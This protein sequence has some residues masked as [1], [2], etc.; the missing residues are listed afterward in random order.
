ME[1]SPGDRFR[2]TQLV[3]GNSSQALGSPIR[4]TAIPSAP[5]GP[6]TNTPALHLF[7]PVRPQASQSPPSDHAEVD[8]CLMAL[9]FLLQSLFQCPAIFEPRSEVPREIAKSHP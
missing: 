1:S 9:S 2:P 3:A 4:E 7:H 6:A 8:A 5:A